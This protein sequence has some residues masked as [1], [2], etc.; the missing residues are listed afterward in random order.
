MLFYAGPVPAGILLSGLY[1]AALLQGPQSRLQHAVLFLKR[2]EHSA[3][4][5][6][7]VPPLLSALPSRRQRALHAAPQP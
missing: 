4:R 1:R 5:L 3:C 6:L 2:L 7:G